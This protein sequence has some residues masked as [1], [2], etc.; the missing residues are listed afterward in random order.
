MKTGNIIHRFVLKNGREV[1]FRKV[2]RKEL[3]DVNQTFVKVFGEEKYPA[4]LL[5]EKHQRYPSLFVAAFDGEGIVG[6][7]FG[8]PDPAILVVKAIAVLKSHR[9]K[10]VGTALLGAFNDA[11]MKEGFDNFALGA[12][13][14]AVPFYLSCGLECFGN[15][16]IKPDKIPWDRIEKLREKYEIISAVVFSPT[17]SGDLVSKLRVFNVR[18]GS[19]ESEFESVSIQFKPATISE[20]AL[21]QTKK[22]FNAFSTQFCFKKEL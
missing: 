16:Q 21:E 11:A 7:V 17:P 2:Q 9:R 10:G 18:V 6:I 19:V 22:D 20:D 5:I 8:W 4:G 13:W 15:A 3:A 1:V 14:E 12:K